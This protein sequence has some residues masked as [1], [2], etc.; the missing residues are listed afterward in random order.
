[1]TSRCSGYFINQVATQ[2][3]KKSPEEEQ[4]EVNGEWATV[5]GGSPEV[6]LT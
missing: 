6:S 4:W 2:V 5:G 3:Q 1:M